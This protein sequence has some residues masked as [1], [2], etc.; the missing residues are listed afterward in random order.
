[1]LSI[2]AVVAS[3]TEWPLERL[4]VLPLVDAKCTIGIDE[5]GRGPVLGPL[6]YGLCICS[7]RSSAWLNSP[8]S[9]A[10]DSKNLTKERREAFFKTLL[11]DNDDDGCDGCDGDN[12]S[13]DKAIAGIG[14]ISKV[15]HPAEISSRM[16]SKSPTTYLNLNE[17]SYST[18]YYLLERAI[19]AVGGEDIITAVFVDTLGKP[20]K[21]TERLEERFPLLKGKFTVKS[22]ADSLFPVVGA[23][24]I[25]AKVI[26]DHVLTEMVRESS[27][28]ATATATA[29]TATTIH[30][31]PSGYPGDQNTV[32]FLRR[33]ILPLYGFPSSVRFSWGSCKGFL[34]DQCLPVSWCDALKPSIAES[35]KTKKKSV[36]INT[37]SDGRS[38]T[39]FGLQ[40]VNF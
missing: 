4:P 30:P 1:M 11:G 35:L 40:S 17:L 31:I 39:I 7:E 25:V 6:V 37:I 16:L 13:K 33:N 2:S 14:W 22:K 34:Q 27:I 24:S 23:A 28:A 36:Q 10:D 5:A 9:G 38:A 19:K 3:P 20:E 15:I 8:L 26:R 29:T 18:V 21:Y 32:N 12:S